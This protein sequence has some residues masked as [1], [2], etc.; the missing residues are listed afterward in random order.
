MKAISL[1]NTT[2]KPHL[3]VIKRDA[4]QKKAITRIYINTLIPE[5]NYTNSLGVNITSRNCVM[6]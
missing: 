3:K 5:F 2:Q 6:L 1:Q 4:K